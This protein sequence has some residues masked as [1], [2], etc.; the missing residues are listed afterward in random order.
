MFEFKDCQITKSG[1]MRIVL[2]DIE[3]NQVFGVF[4]N[5]EKYF[6]MIKDNFERNDEFPKEMYTFKKSFDTEN[7]FKLVLIENI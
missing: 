5:N 4:T 2:E 6:N 7:K 1:L 3:T